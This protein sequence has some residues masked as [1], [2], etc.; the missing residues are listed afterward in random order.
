MT[1]PDRHYAGD[2]LEFRVSVPDYPPGDGWQL[3]YRFIPRFT[4]PPQSPIDLIATNDGDE[5]V[6][7]AAPSVTVGWVPGMYGWTRYV[8]KSGARQVLDD[9]DS[10]GQL[11]ILADPVT[12]GQ[13]HDNRTQAQRALDV[14]RQALA[15]FTANNDGRVKRYS[16]AGR[17]MEFHSSAEVVRV[18]RYWEQQVAAEVAAERIARGLD[19]GRTVRVRF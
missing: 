4:S 1:M 6:L 15:D 18:V 17:E 12:V 2:T 7:S 13:G 3:R 9:L 8:I 11:E 16:I 19:T 5:Y 14:A 10:R